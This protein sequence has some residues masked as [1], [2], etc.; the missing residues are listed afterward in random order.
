M[1]EALIGETLWRDR[2]AGSPGVI[3]QSIRLNDQPFTIVG[4]MPAGFNVPGQRQG[5]VW[6]NT[7]AAADAP[8]TV[9][10]EHNRPPGTRRDTRGR[11]LEAHRCGYARAR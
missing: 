4:V 8:W 1:L 6:Q 5:A 7:T 2:Y 10:P 11:R 3:G 9:L